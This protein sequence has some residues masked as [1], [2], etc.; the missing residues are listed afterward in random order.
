MRKL[1]FSFLIP[2]S[3]TLFAGCHTMSRPDIAG[4]YRGV[5]ESPGGELAFPITIIQTDSGYTGYVCNGMDT[6]DFSG[7]R[8]GKDSV[9][10]DFGFYDS[11]LIAA[12][13]S[14][15]GLAGRW[16]KHSIGTRILNLPF[17]A[18]KGVTYRYSQKTPASSVFEG[19]WPAVFHKTSDTTRGYPATGV[20][21]SENG[22]LYG[23]FLTETGD[24]RFLQ[25]FAKDSSMTLSSFDGA[26]AYLFRAHL[27]PDGTIQGNFWSYKTRRTWTA[28]KGTSKLPDPF[29]IATIDPKHPD[30]TFSLPDV[31]HHMVSSDDPEFK[32]KPILLYIFGSWCPNCA[33]ETAMLKKIYPQYRKTGLQIV[34]V[35]F[36]YFDTFEQKAEMVRRYKQRFQIPWTLVI[37]GKATSEDVEKSLPFVRKLISYPTDYFAGAD[38]KIRYIHVGFDGPGTGSY[39]FQEKKAFKEKLDNITQ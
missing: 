20:F 6:L 27:Q 39:Y 19:E 38:H 4:K 16:T 35:A 33:D 23:T 18:E 21:S 28:H 15:G 7:I 2:A 22:K 14:D 5:I 13:G 29:D 26:S 25:G 24:Y 30:I 12:V 3:F 9:S 1:L 11:H 31:D 8:V 34:G 32:G 37:G 10:L 17:H 36:E